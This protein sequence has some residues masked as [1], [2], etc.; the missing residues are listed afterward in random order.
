[1]DILVNTVGVGVLH[2]HHQRPISPFGSFLNC[3]PR[4]ISVT[5]ASTAVTKTTT[6]APHP[7]T[8]KHKR[9]Q[10]VEGDLYVNHTC[11]DCDVCRWMAPET[12]S[13][14][15][16]QSAVYKQPDSA[17]ERTAA[18]QA[19]LSCPVGSIRTEKPPSDILQVH[20]TMP[21]S[22]DEKCLPGVYHCG[23]HSKK[24]YGAASYLIKHPKGNILVDSPSFKEK[25]ASKID[26]LGGAR[27]MFLSHRDDV[28][29]HDKWAKRL[30]CDRILHINEVQSHTAD[31]E[32]KLEGQGPWSLNPD[33]DLIFTPGHTEGSVSLSYKP[34]KA[35]FTGDHL[36]ASHNGE[37]TYFEKYNWY[38]V[39]KQ[40]QNIHPFLQMDFL[41]ILPG[42]GRR[43]KFENINEKNAAIEKLLS[44]VGLLQLV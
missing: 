44:G 11:I 26:E 41:W 9:P 1:M 19:L 8:L 2:K 21:L 42:H 14:V 33:V 22:I 38:S 39:E 5:C 18:L 43:I 7:P 27:Y 29:D 16:G 15:D 28:A 25:L 40:V 36:A 35:L 31:V 30:S 4:R 10:N 12:F 34:L 37:L 17:E 32:I 20:S 6:A 3:T 13:R 23:Y 24:S